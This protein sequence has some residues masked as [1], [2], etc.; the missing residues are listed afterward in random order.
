MQFPI[1]RLLQKRL[2]RSADGKQKSEEKM[3]ALISSQIEK[4]IYDSCL[5]AW[6]DNYRKYFE[7]EDYP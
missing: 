4:D 6:E 2:F 5:V 7:D 3:G 1:P